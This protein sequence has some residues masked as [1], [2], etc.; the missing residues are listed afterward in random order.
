MI[1]AIW[2]FGTTQLLLR[3][4]RLLVQSRLLAT[5]PE[6]ADYAPSILYRTLG[7]QLPDNSA[8]A[9]FLWATAHQFARKNPDAVRRAGHVGEG[10]MLGERLFEAILSSRSGA[11]FSISEYEESWSFI[12]HDDGKIHLEIPEMLS[13]LRELDPVEPVSATNYPFILVA[14]ERRSYNANTIYRNPGWRK[15]D[16]DG[17]LKINPEDAGA[18]GLM[19]GGWARCESKRGS[20][21]VRVEISDSI[22]RGQVTL[23]HGY[24]MEYP[25]GDGKRRATGA[26]INELTAAEDRDPVAGTPYHKYIPVRLAPIEYAPA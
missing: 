14:G 5:K 21:V 12:K 4:T 8:A 13:A 24:G 18:L 6:L 11:V 1:L 15:T 22:R 17:A 19:D 3:Q 2:T 26:H 20:V 7:P 9:A 23:P 10:P 25:D 16:P